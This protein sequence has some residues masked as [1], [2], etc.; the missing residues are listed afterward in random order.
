MRNT[1]A[2]FKLEIEF[3]NWGS[4]GESYIHPFGSC[5]KDMSNFLLHPD[6][7]AEGLDVL[8]AKGDIVR[9]CE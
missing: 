9:S 8:F 4:I 7:P 6:F 5:W 3:I 2:T 1:Q